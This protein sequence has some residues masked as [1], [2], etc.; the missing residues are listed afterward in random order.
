MLNK[1]N[2]Q[3]PYILIVL[4]IIL[5][6]IKTMNIYYINS[7]L[8][9]IDSFVNVYNFLKNNSLYLLFIIKKTKN[10]K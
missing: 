8:L 2:K 3:I 1:Y 7:L 10:V 4:I 5:L 6:I 9:N